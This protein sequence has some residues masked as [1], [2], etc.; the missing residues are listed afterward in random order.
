MIWTIN[1]LNQSSL[2]K[3][4]SAGKVARACLD[5]CAP[6]SAMFFGMYHNLP[7]VVGYLQSVEKYRSDIIPVSR[8]EL[9]YWPGGLENLATRYPQMTK[10]SF[11][12]PFGDSLRYLAPRSSRH[13][14]RFSQENARDLLFNNNVWMADE[15]TKSGS[16]YWFPSEDDHLLRMKL[17]P[18]G[19]ML[20]LE[21]LE[22]FENSTLLPSQIISSRLQINEDNKFNKEK[23]VVVI[24]T[25]DD[26]LFI[27]IKNRGMLTAAVAASESMMLSDPALAG[28]C[29][30]HK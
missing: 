3:D 8:G 17:I 16:V 1:N 13:S 26:L 18:W 20:K 9:V 4:E 27:T 22:R 28:N 15:F 24:A 14:G 2:A 5:I 30:L 19:P 23:G 10:A 29:G 12:G 6:D 21:M 7:F 25:Y 11:Q